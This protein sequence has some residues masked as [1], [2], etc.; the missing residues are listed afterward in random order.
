LGRELIIPA[1]KLIVVA[2]RDREEEVLRRLGELGVIQLKEP[3]EK[4]FLRLIKEEARLGEL[5]KLYERLMEIWRDLALGVSETSKGLNSLETGDLR[6]SFI[7]FIPEE[8]S[9]LRSTREL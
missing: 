4:D 9:R 2:L 1:K 7:G 5:E 3:S 8:D 6:P